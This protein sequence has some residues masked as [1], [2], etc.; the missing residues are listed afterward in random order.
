M[1]EINRLA[2]ERFRGITE[3]QREELAPEDVM[4]L[5]A[6]GLDEAILATLLGQQQPAAAPPVGGGDS[7]VP[8]ENRMRE[9]EQIG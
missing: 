5:Q 3:L 1:A 4:A 9:G 6:L 2:A 8:S 7:L